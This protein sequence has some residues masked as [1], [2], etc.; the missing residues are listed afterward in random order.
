MTA[1]SI[2]YQIQ[3]GHKSAYFAFRDELLVFQELPYRNNKFV[4]PFPV[5]GFIVFCIRVLS[6]FYVLVDTRDKVL[7]SSKN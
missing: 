3:M 2:L 7:R 6:A 1:H 5:H 4:K